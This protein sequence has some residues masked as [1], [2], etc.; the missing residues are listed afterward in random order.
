MKNIFK[1]HKKCKFFISLVIIGLY[2]VYF[3]VTQP[4][5]ITYQFPKNDLFPQQ[6]PVSDEKTLQQHV[7]FLSTRDR[8][9]VVGQQKII[10][11]L[12]Q[13]LKESGIKDSDIERQHYSMGK[14]HYQNIIVHFRTAIQEAPHYI[15]GAHYDAYSNVSCFSTAF[16][17]PNMPKMLPGA[18]DN[19][20]GVAG[21]L[22]LAKMFNQ[23]KSIDRNIDLVFYSTEEPPFYATQNM[24]SYHHAKKAKNVD[25]AII[26]E[27]IG[28]FS[29][30]E[31]SQHFPLSSM[32][33]FYP[34]KGNFIA[35]VSNFDN[36]MPTR[37]VKRRF[38]HFLAKENAIGVASINAP[39]SVTGIDFSDHRNYWK[40]DIPAL[41]ITD[42]SFYRNRNYH[43]INDTYEKLDY[44]KM[45]AVVDA[46][47]ITALS[48]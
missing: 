29:E 17:D 32:K 25:L 14:N 34:D 15:I 5:F 27:M 19:A 16:C 45:K 1:K 4:L 46:T 2:A 21:L 40:F 24:G 39:T 8:T 23:I 18:D 48:L 7:K 31:N 10:A 30:A 3:M 28:Y 42:T 35:V 13:M 38:A 44:H 6:L 22:E 26:L 41:M 37:A 36:I 12:L 20:S 47:F 9:S 33:Y 43:T 11:Y